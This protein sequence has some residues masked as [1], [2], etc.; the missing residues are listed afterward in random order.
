MQ[1]LFILLFILFS[2][3]ILGDNVSDSLLLSYYDASILPVM[4]MVNALFL[5]L[6]S[7]FF[8]TLIDR[9]DRGLLLMGVIGIHL[10]MLTAVKFAMSAGLSI[11]YPFLYSYSYAS[12]MMLFM[13][14]WTVVNDIVDARDAKRLFPKIAAGGVL[15]GITVS[16]AAAFLAKRTG[17]EGLL[18]IWMIIVAS[19]FPV[20]WTIHRRFLPHLRAVR[21]PSS[22]GNLFRKLLDFRLLRR[23]PLLRHMALIYFLTF[24]LLYSHDFIFLSTL[25]EN[26]L[27]AKSELITRI[28]PA[29]V[30]S[31]LGAG[32]DA[33][34]IILKRAVP[35]FLGLFK[36]AAN[37]FTLLLQ[38]TVAG[39][40]LRSLGT[41]RAM[42]VMPICFVAAFGAILLGRFSL[43]P[44]F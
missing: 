26:F 19:S 30:H 36:G 32:E 10:T 23:D 33:D 12:K 6:V 29:Q 24:I 37:T 18:L 35:T 34:A 21:E 39:F 43:L 7:S 15:G 14:F 28:D 25:K 41:V 40:I 5:F 9:V 22:S 11:A 4:F 17:A 38:F 31:I 8:M 42:L 27:A 1:R 20:A 44:D 3:V 16:F 2:S 13:V